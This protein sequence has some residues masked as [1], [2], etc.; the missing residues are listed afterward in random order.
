MVALV[1]DVNSTKVVWPAV[2]AIKLIHPLENSSWVL[3]MVN[4]LGLLHC[5][6][7]IISRWSQSIAC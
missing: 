4:W 5:P 3:G 6:I 7:C 1:K 2:T